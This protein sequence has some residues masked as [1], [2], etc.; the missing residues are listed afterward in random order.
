MFDRTALG[1]RQARQMH[2]AGHVAADQNV[3]VRFENV[4]EL[5]RPHPPGN[6]RE[7]NGKCSTEPAALL[8]LS[9]WRND[10]VAN[11]L[12]Q[13]QCRL[14]TTRTTAVAGPMKGDAR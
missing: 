4:I 11:G 3:G 5:Q 13:F 10:G 2:E 12:Q 9:E 1:G 6:M 7:G 8:G 14:T